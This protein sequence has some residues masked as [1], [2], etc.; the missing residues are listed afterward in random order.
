MVLH[1]V[2]YAWLIA[3][4]WK[5]RFSHDEK[6]TPGLKC[7]G[8]TWQDV[9]DGLWIKN[10]GTKMQ[11]TSNYLDATDLDA[12]QWLYRVHAVPDAKSKCVL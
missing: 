6:W 5:I 10:G 7:L 1:G 8:K 9:Y 2:P 11:S 3:S 4:L 12:T